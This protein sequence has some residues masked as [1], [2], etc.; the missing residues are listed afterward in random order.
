MQENYNFWSSCDNKHLFL[1]FVNKEKAP[2]KFNDLCL[3]NTIKYWK[4]YRQECLITLKTLVEAILIIFLYSACGL[5]VLFVSVLKGDRHGRHDERQP[6]K[7]WGHQTN[8]HSADTK[9]F[10]D[11]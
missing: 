6:N 3:I 10:P 9:T 11:K 2:E 8:Y 7:I 1:V 5:P 4:S